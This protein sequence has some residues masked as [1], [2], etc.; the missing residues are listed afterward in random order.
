MSVL[1][2]PATIVLDCADPVALADFYRKATGWEL[3]HSD[4][5][6]AALAP[7]GPGPGLAFA[8]V[9]EGEGHR[10]RGWPEGGPRLHLDFPVADLPS[11]VEE[12]T[13]LGATRPDFQP[14][15]GEWVVL[16]DPQGHPFCLTPAGA[17]D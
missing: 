6:F 5:D 13:A 1:N 2:R 14:G 4:A 15:G 12:L 3:T 10:G 7:A 11:V 8:R 16:L 17:D 9:E